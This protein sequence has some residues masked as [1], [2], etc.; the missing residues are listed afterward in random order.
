MSREDRQ[1]K[2]KK[3]LR[4]SENVGFFSFVGMIVILLGY[5]FYQVIT[6]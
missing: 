1:G 6:M 3:Q 2:S 4:Y 5:Y